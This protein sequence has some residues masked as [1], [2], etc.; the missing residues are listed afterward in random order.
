M[1]GAGCGQ[2][3]PRRAQEAAAAGALVDDEL[4]AAVVLDPE[5]DFVDE[6]SEEVLEPSEELAELTLLVP[7]RLSVR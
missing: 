4:E 7:F 1:N 6:D 3:P 2:L 5:S